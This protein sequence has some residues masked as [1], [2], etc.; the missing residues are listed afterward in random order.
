VLKI[1]LMTTYKGK[2]VRI[3]EKTYQIMKNELN[4]MI[5]M[6]KFVEQAIIEKIERDKDYY[7]GPNIL[8]E[9]VMNEFK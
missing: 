2:N 7:R 6:S 3:S 5:V 1:I 8:S 4:P 9:K